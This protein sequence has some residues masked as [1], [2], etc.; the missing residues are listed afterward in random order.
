[1][2]VDKFFHLNNKMQEF[3]HE[4]GLFMPDSMIFKIDNEEVDAFQIFNSE[5]TDAQILEIYQGG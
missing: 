1:M 3:R 5:L 4:E 2:S